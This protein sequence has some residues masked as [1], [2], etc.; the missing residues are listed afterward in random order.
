MDIVAKL[1]TLDVSLYFTHWSCD[2]QGGYAIPGVMFDHVYFQDS[3]IISRILSLYWRYCVSFRAD[4]IFQG[5]KLLY[6]RD[7]PCDF[8]A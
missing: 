2:F 5:F 4:A 6:F 7:W 8:Q 1:Y 3:C